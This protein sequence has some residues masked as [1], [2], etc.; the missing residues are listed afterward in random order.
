MSVILRCIEV[1]QQVGP[2]ITAHSISVESNYVFKELQM[3]DFHFTPVISPISTDTKC[4]TACESLQ[5]TTS[6]WPS[7]IC[8]II[9]VKLQRNKLLS[10]LLV[11]PVKTCLPS[12]RLV[13]SEMCHIKGPTGMKRPHCRRVGGKRRLQFECL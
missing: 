5:R 8:L 2:D 3:Q 4:G 6:K 11:V 10:H 9:F 13:Y 1:C 7:L 12:T